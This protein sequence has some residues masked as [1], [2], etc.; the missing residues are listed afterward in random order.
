MYKK[1]LF[2]VARFDAYSKAFLDA[3][4]PSIP[5]GIFESIFIYIIIN[6]II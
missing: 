3:S 6:F 2:L 5:T 1:E 4:E